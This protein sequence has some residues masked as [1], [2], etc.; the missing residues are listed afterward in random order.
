LDFG[1][2]FGDTVGVLGVGGILGGEVLAGKGVFA[3][4]FDGAEI[5]EAF[6]TGLGGGL[7]ELGGGGGVDGAEG[8]QG[9]G[10]GVVHLVDTGGQVN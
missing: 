2:G 5:D 10:G 8:G 6:D 9:V 1:F 4:D 3:V 7:G